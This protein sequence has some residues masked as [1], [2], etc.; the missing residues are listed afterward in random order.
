MCYLI[1]HNANAT[2]VA[3]KHLHRVFFNQR[4]S[5]VLY[6][7]GDIWGPAPLFSC[8]QRTTSSCLPAPQLET[9]RADSILVAQKIHDVSTA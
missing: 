1:F 9:R 6:Q 7:A 2:Y 8:P 4:K 5:P 3:C